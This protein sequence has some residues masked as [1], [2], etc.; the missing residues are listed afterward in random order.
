MM[1]SVILEAI[2]KSSKPYVFIGQLGNITTNNTTITYKLLYILDCLFC[3]RTITSSQHLSPPP[4]P[5]FP[6]LLSYP[7][8]TS[9]SS[10]LYFLSLSLFLMWWLLTP[11]SCRHHH[12]LPPPPC[13]VIQPH[14]FSQLA[15]SFHFVRYLLLCLDLYL[16]WL[17]WHRLCPATSDC[18]LCQSYGFFFS[19][20]IIIFN[21]RAAIFCL[22]ALFLF[23]MLIFYAFLTLSDLD[24]GI[25]GHSMFRFMSSDLSQRFF[26]FPA[27]SLISVS[28]HLLY[29]TT[30][31]HLHFFFFFFFFPPFLF[32]RID[33]KWREKGNIGL[34]WGGWD[35]DREN[36]D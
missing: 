4:P 17:G 27:S 22:P 19:E 11:S 21:L 6:P 30:F 3:W 33:I 13:N 10:L 31:V 16:L 18:Q 1:I 5:P 35:D 12:G 26:L 7:D 34:G 28:V 8:Y 2:N 36:L 23:L 25:W 20:L 15:H 24:F 14:P 29:C 32:K 9:S